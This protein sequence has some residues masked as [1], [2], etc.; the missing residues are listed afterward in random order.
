MH[1][2]SPEK[3]QTRS[4]WRRLRQPHTLLGGTLVRAEEV[5]LARGS[6]AAV[7]QCALPTDLLVSDA[8][9]GKGVSGYGARLS[10]TGLQADPSHDSEV[11]A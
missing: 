7:Q 2:P 10:R 1:P 9:S 5:A 8:P 3:F 6:L 11:R 4:S